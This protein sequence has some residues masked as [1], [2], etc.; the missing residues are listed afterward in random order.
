MKPDEGT[1]VAAAGAWR[2]DGASAAIEDPRG[3]LAGALLAEVTLKLASG[4]ASEKG[5]LPLPALIRREEA[6]RIAK[7]YGG[8][9]RT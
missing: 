5:L 6:E 8:N 1:P 9:I 7:E 3:I 4:G 2:E